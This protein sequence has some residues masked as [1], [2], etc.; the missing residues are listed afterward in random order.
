MSRNPVNNFVPGSLLTIEEP[1][2]L[3]VD[4]YQ[5][6]VGEGTNYPT[7][8]SIT[9]PDNAFIYV[10]GDFVIDID[11]AYKGVK[12]EIAPDKEIFVQWNVTLRLD[13]CILFSCVGKWN[14]IRA[15]S[16]AKIFMQSSEL[17]RA[18][19]GISYDNPLIGGVLS[20]KN[21]Y[22][23]DNEVSVY[24]GAATNAL[25]PV[26][27]IEFHNNYFVGGIQYP[28]N[29]AIYVE[30]MPLILPFNESGKNTIINVATGIFA[31]KCSIVD[32]NNIDMS[33]INKGIDYDMG[34]VGTFDCKF[35]NAK[36][37]GI[38]IGR[39]QDANIDFCLFD[40]VYYFEYFVWYF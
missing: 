15:Q 27:V 30:N 19:R 23:Q 35:T 40:V 18:T 37:A 32:I 10:E 5:Y 34:I 31:R 20:L 33:H 29:S 36:S 22:F 25:I 13:E 38:D 7:A 28:S 17:Y 21:N 12:F 9:I 4:L 8:S 16:A 6:Y 39:C 1:C 2:D 11:V 26:S 14:G 3:Y 24:L